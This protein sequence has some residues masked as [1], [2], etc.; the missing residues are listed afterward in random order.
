MSNLVSRGLNAMR[1]I[2]SWGGKEQAHLE[3]HDL[4]RIREQLQ[5]C[6]EGQACYP[7]AGGYFSCAPDASG[8]SGAQGEP[9]EFINVCDEGLTCITSDA[10]G[11]DEAAFGCCTSFCE[12]G[13][14]PC[15]DGLECVPYFNS[16]SEAPPG[17]QNVGMCLTSGW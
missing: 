5:D 17:L 2:I 11:C 16:A 6:A 12:L 4:D 7:M 10:V 3:P 14:A 8:D 1:A 15:P 9:C 13:G